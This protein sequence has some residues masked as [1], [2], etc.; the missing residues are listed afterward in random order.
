MADSLG[1]PA[2]TGALVLSTYTLPGVAVA[3]IVGLL[4]DRFG[5]K[6]V[7]IP[8]L[9]FHGL[10]GGLCFF[11]PN[12]KVLLILRFLQGIGSAGLVNLVVV[13]LGDLLSGIQ[14]AR[15]IGYNAA[16]LTV[17]TMTFPTLG[18]LLASSNWRNAYIP[19]WAVLAIALGVAVI[20][21]NT[22]GTDGVGDAGVDRVSGGVLSNFR[23]VLAVAAVRRIMLRGFIVFV[24]IFGGILAGVPVMLGERLHANPTTIG[25]FL[26]AGSIASMVMATSA[27]RLRKRLSPSRILL[28]AFPA[29]AFGMSIL[30]VVS[31]TASRPLAVIAIAACGIGEGMAVVVLQTR[32]TEVAP[33]G[34]RGTS[35]AMFVS[36]ARLGQTT[37]PVVAKAGLDRIGFAASFAAFAALAGLM[38]LG[39]L[40]R[41]RRSESETDASGT[42]SLKR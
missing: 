21:P 6:A 5:R 11:A 14:R 25:L 13:T 22:K 19:F 38:A 16:V 24:L 40:R 29:Y 27:G 34:L 18:G 20:L 8:A 17:G 10:G 9:L 7:M 23:R 39:Q 4:A 1:V 41:T 28:L 26:T 12:F 3:P 30:A 33:P 36:S 31:L 15:F 42:K 35:V 32:A 37:G 2:T